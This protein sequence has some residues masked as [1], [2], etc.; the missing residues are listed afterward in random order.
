MPLA[1]S[2]T[3]PLQPTVGY[4]ARK[5]GDTVHVAKVLTRPQPRFR[6]K[7]KQMKQRKSRLPSGGPSRLEEESVHALT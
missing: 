6:P 4:L 1:K 2:S 7:I 5:Q 3:P